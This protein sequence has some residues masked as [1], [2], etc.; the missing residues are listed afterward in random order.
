MLRVAV[1]FAL[2]ASAAAL[3]EIFNLR[4]AVQ[5]DEEREG[6]FLVQIHTAW[7]PI[8]ARRLW[9][10]VESSIWKGSPVHKVQKGHSVQWGISPHPVAAQ[11]WAKKRIGDDPHMR[12]VAN[13][14][15]YFT[16]AKGPDG[17]R[18]TQVFINLSRNTYLDLDTFPPLGHVI[19]GY[20]VVKEIFDGY[21]PDAVD[22]ERLRNEGDRYTRKEFPK[23]SYIKSA[24]IERFEPPRKDD[25]L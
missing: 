7:A 16:F 24:T 14:E 2:A 22:E 10:I 5:I 19:E 4:I 13:R 11:K 15:R 17:S 20:E 6:E 3:P 9:D 1:L 18:T 8:G 12:N 21:A 23:M 25:E